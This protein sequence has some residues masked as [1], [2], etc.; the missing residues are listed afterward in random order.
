MPLELFVFLGTVLD[1]IISPIPAFIILVPAGIAAHVQL[2]PPVYLL[3]LAVLS[4]VA[5]TLAG[6][7]L[8]I[9]ADKFEDVLFAHGRRLFKVSHTDIE[10]FGKRLS[11]QKASKSWWALFVMHALPVFPGTILSMGSGFIRLRPSIFLTATL[12]GSF[13][14]A[15]FYLGL[16]YSGIQA[17]EVVGG[18]DKMA[19]IVTALFIIAVIIWVIQLYRKNAGGRLKSKRH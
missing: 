8:Y 3:L 5:R 13:M 9:V 10:G 19:Q 18:L 7:V 11:H 1:E 17:S 14:S 15:V 6:Y 4:A 2:H 16:G 12:G